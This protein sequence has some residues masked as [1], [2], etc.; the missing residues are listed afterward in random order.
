MNDGT[1]RTQQQNGGE[2]SIL[3]NKTIFEHN[4]KIEIVIK[5]THI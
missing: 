1:K 4:S 3:E 5:V 2:S